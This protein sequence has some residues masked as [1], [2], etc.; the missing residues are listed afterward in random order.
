MKADLDIGT[1][2]DWQSFRRQ[3]LDTI[4]DPMIFRAGDVFVRGRSGARETLQATDDVALWGALTKDLTGLTTFFDQLVI[5]E[6]LPLIDY[7]ITFDS[8][9][10]YDTP[11]IADHVNEALQEKVV[12]TVHVHGEASEEA[13]RSA[14]AAMPERPQ[15]PPELESSIVSELGALDHAWRPDLEG[16]VSAGTEEQLALARF[17]YGGLV[18]S[19]FSQLT[20]CM[21]VLQPKR[22]RLLTA[23]ALNAPSASHEHERELY[24]ALDRRVRRTPG[25]REIGFGGL[26]SFVPFLLAQECPE[27]PLQLLSAIGRLR[28]DGVVVEYREFRKRLLRD[29]VD[30][31]FI[32]E[33][34]ERGIKK[35]ALRLNDKLSVDRKV[36]LEVGLSASVEAK[37]VGIDAG[38]KAAVPVDRIWGWIL[39]RIPGHRYVKLLTRLQM[40]QDRYERLDR[41]LHQLWTSA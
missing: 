28:K 40:A 13:R 34:N 21:H 36:D 2:D 30:K 41:H 22:A 3:R 23:L 20:G 16:R 9:L 1:K 4:V 26:P 32:D 27:G 37:G 17:A 38:V 8:A 33:A 10:Q 14:L 5:S 15:A 29:W 7:G 12:V 35:L 11:W 18:F 31:G 19:A 39:D 25:L 6:R 24:A